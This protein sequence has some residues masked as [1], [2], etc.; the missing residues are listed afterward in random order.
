MEAVRFG[1]VRYAVAVA[2]LAACGGALS[3]VGTIRPAAV[4]T[5]GPSTAPQFTAAIPTALPFRLTMSPATHTTTSGS[6]PAPP[7]IGG[8]APSLVTCA[9]EAAFPK[10]VLDGPGPPQAEVFSDPPGEAL[11]RR[12]CIVG[13]AN[14]R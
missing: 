10:A 1:H 12:T 7:P 6:I 13:L 8:S 5:S 11:S 14:R 2:L 9:E 4:S 3:A